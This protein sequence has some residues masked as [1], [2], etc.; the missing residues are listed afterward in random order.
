MRKKTLSQ[1]SE[2]SRRRNR[3]GSPVG[4]RDARHGGNVG[5]GGGPLDLVGTA[6]CRHEQR[7]ARGTRGVR[8][9]SSA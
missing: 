3:S 7:F 8:L 5:D 9:L 6:Q 4:R 1:M 2:N